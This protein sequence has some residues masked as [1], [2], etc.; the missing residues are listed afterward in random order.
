[1][2]RWDI[3]VYLRENNFWHMGHLVCPLWMLLWC[4]N[5]SFRLKTLPHTLHTY[6]AEL[7]E[8]VVGAGGSRAPN[9]SYVHWATTE[10]ENNLYF[11]TLIRPKVINFYCFQSAFISSEQLFTLQSIRLKEIK[12]RSKNNL[13]LLLH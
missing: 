7:P 4:A 1:M 9:S 2:K 12:N 6:F 10:R 5:E 11:Y 3:I 8:D 13:I